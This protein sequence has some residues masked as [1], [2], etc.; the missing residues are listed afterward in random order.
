MNRSNERVGVKKDERGQF[1]CSIV[2]VLEKR[3]EKKKKKSQ[4]IPV[5]PREECKCSEK[6]SSNTLV[7]EIHE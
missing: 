4:R 2:L 5:T 6:P 3:Y 1:L 7:K